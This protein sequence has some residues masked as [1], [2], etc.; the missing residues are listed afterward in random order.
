MSD[1]YPK[2]TENKDLIYQILNSEIDKFSTNLSRGKLV[3][4]KN[5]QES[6]TTKIISQMINGRNSNSKCKGNG[7]Y[8]TGNSGPTPLTSC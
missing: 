3:L 2:L 4:E 6:T 7:V 1:I 8:L 5:L